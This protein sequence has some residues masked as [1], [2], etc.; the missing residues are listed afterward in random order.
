[1]LWIRKYFKADSLWY[2]LFLLI[3]RGIK[4]I[5]FTSK[6]AH[7][8]NKECVEIMVKIDKNIMN[9]NNMFEGW[10]NMNYIVY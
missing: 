9:R 1:M 10:R 6:A 4:T 5:I 3:I 7:T 2:L 8:I